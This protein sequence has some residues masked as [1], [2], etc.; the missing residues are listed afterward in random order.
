MEKSFIFPEDIRSKF[1]SK[2][3]L[4]KRLSIDCKHLYFISNNSGHFSSLVFQ[5]NNRFHEKDLVWWKEVSFWFTQSSN[6]LLKFRYILNRHL[7]SFEIPNY[8]E[9]WTRYVS[10]LINENPN[11]MKYFPD[12]KESQLSENEFMYGILGTLMPYELRE[13]IAQIMKSRSPLGQEDK[14]DLI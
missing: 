5:M 7:V 1:R 11:L 8:P 10:P 9:L 3:D 2:S 12:L 13:M 6:V 4:W 14:N